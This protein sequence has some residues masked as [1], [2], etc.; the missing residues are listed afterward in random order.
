M[1]KRFTQKEFIK[2]AIETHGDKYDYSEAVYVNKNT[3]VCIICPAHGRFWQKPVCHLN[4]KCDCP[5]CAKTAVGKSKRS[6]P[7][8]FA[9]LARRIHGDKYDYSQTGFTTYRAG[10]IKIICP[11][12][13]EFRQMPGEHLRGS[14]CPRCRDSH[15]ERAIAAELARRNIMPE[16]NKKFADLG[17]L[18]YDFYIPSKN[19]LI[20]YNGEQHYIQASFGHHDLKKQRHYDWLKRKYAR[21][22]GTR[23]LIIPYWEYRNIPS[24][25]K[26]A[27]ES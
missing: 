7:E 18:S 22:H 26:T 2:R 1:P 6:S 16:R 5:E 4:N 24:I 17:S 19:L 15:G 3:E 9:E 25:L 13:G 21:K 11:I 23:L 10:K 14:G 27:L 12:H 8:R 20:E